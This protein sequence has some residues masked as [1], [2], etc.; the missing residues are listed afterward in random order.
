MKL[1]A[2]RL[3]RPTQAVAL[4][5]AA[6]AAAL[7][8]VPPFVHFDHLAH[9]TTLDLVRDGTALHE[10]VVAGQAAIGNAVSQ[11]RSVREPWIFALWSLVP[12]S[13][14]EVLFFVVVAGGSAVVIAPVLRFPPAALLVTAYL[15]WFGSYGEIEQWLLSEPWTAPLVLGAC[16]AWVR[17]RWGLASAAAVAATLVRENCVL[18]QLGFLVF[19][20]RSGRAVRPWAVGLGV[21]AA[22]LV[23]HAALA[24]P[25]LHDEG[26]EAALLGSGD[27]AFVTNMTRLFGLPGL[28]GLGVWVAGLV[29][30]WRSQ[31]RPALPLALIPLSGF[32]V[33]RPYW[34]A[35][36]MPLCLAA[37]GGLPPA[38]GLWPDAGPNR[39]PGS[40]AA[41]SP[42]GAPDP[43][44]TTTS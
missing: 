42:G 29:L 36:A 22:S 4:V 40:A 17:G 7:A 32:V 21:T 8:P 26:H 19:A 33:G 9:R 16:V 37:L 24:A 25:H 35:L 28:V 18:L 12:T 38:T 31:L 23:V 44:G 6:V 11:V 43:R 5:G 13:W 14:V 39:A 3:V 27:P 10:A 15:A 20:W 41:T 30:L 1:D 34:G 2:A